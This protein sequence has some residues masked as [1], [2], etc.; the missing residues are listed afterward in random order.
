[1]HTLKL[2]KTYKVGN[3]CRYLSL[4]DCRKG[5]ARPPHSVQYYGIFPTL[6]LI[7]GLPVRLHPHNTITRLIHLDEIYT[8]IIILT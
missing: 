2:T 7:S 4:I 6:T 8:N 3:S 1:M 5:F